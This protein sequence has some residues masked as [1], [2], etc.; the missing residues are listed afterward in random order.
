MVDIEHRAL[1]TF[2]ENAPPG[3][4]RLVQ[5]LPDPRGEGSEARRDVSS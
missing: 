1:G 4:A 3:P 5:P 2:E